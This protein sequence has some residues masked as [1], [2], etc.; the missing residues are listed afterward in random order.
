MQYPNTPHAA[1]YFVRHGATSANLAGLRCGG[2]L[3]LP[4]TDLGRRQAH[5]AARQVAAL[6][7]PVGLI[8]TS[9]LQRTRETA[10][11]LAAALPGVA[12]LVAPALGERRLGE[13][14]L[15]PIDETQ[16]WLEAC[17]PPPGGETEFEF[18]NRIRHAVQALAPQLT[19]ASQAGTRALLVGSK[20]VGRVLGQLA[21]RPDRVEL[22]N[23]EFASFLMPLP[24]GTAPAAACTTS[25]QS[26]PA[27][28]APAA[29]PCLA[30][31]GD[32]L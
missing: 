18:V 26:A 31:S 27:A 8:V 7:P 28:P 21:G 19:A 23:T 4:L 5:A 1:L 13:W 24:A 14:N 25:A 3:D 22:G 6:S 32:L 10:A 9:D 16:P 11:V 15:R 29:T 12:V 17:L 2:D 30:T 20:G